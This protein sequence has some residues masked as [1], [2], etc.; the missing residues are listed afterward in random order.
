MKR[1][2]KIF[3]NYLLAMALPAM[4][5]FVLFALSFLLLRQAGEFMTADNIAQ[6]QLRTGGVYNSALHQM[7]Y[8]YKLELY[9]RVRPG[10]IALGSS[11]ALQF[12]Q[13]SIRPSFLNM[14][15]VSGLDELDAQVGEIMRL[16]APPTALLAVDVWWF[17][18]GYTEPL[19]LP[20]NNRQLDRIAPSISLLAKPFLWLAF[21]QAGV[22]DLLR[23]A[24][25]DARDLGAFAILRGDGYAVDGSYAYTSI[26]NG[27]RPSD[28]PRFS[29]TLA[30]ID[31]LDKLFTP[32]EHV[33]KARWEKFLHIVRALQDGGTSVILV[34]PPF[35]T[36]VLARLSQSSL[37]AYIG[38]L[39]RE[40][41][42]SGPPFFDFHDP[43]TLGSSD[44]EF[45][46]GLHGGPVVYRRIADRLAR[47]YPRLF[48]TVPVRAGFASM[49]KNET[50]FLKLECKKTP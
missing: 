10:M 38:E 47:T 34:M 32:A 30:R 27:K 28:D 13:D 42:K 9:R 40:L 17:N 11:R 49:D 36:P 26:I 21:G 1:P 20:R 48:K 2:V 14:G 29:G 3:N 22:A 25:P 19:N 5:V 12:R 23:L 41:E 43:A 7:T 18:D 37:Y 4:I 33:S 35:P 50:D 16:G 31:R 8:K 44:C 6:R 39:R 45:I 24:K 46:D 15:G